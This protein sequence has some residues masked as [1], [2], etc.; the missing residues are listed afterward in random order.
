MWGELSDSFIALI[1]NDL[2]YKLGFVLI[3]TFR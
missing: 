3:L 2:L 1:R